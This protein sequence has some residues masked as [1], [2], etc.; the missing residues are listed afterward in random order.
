MLDTIEQQLDL[1]F[2]LV[3]QVAD[4]ILVTDTEGAIHYVNSAFEKSSG[5]TRAEILGKPAN[6]LKSGLHDKAFYTKLWNTITCGQPFA[7]TFINRRK[8]G[9]IFYEQ[10]TIT[11]L[12][13]HS[14]AITHY[15]ATGKDITDA[16]EKEERLHYLS[17][18]DPFTDIPN[19]RWLKQELEHALQAKAAEQDSLAVMVLGL[20]RFKR[21]N[22][23][24][25]RK[26]GDVLMINTVRKLKLALDEQTMLAR[27]GGDVFAFLVHNP[28]SPSA[29]VHTAQALL[30]AIASSE[31]LNDQE[32]AITG[33]IGIS[34]Y[35]DD[36]NSANTLLQNAET[37]MFRAK[38]ELGGN[39]FEFFTP[40]MNSTTL[41]RLSLESALYKALENDEF[42]LHYQP[43][44]DI[45]TGRIIGTE[46][47]LR[48]NN[49]Q[50]G[51][52]GPDEF[53]PILE[54]TGMINR[55]GTWVLHKACEQCAKWH[56]AGYDDLLLSVNISAVQFRHPDLIDTIFSILDDTGL[57]EHHLHLEV[58][59]NTVMQDMDKVVSILN[60]LSSMNVKLSI[61]DFGTGYS[62]LLYLQ[63]FPFDMLKLD[64][65]FV[66][67]IENS[68]SDEAIASAIITLAKTLGLSVVAEGVETRHQLSQLHGL[69]C[70]VMQGYLFSRPLTA[71]DMLLL[72]QSGR[73]L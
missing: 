72:L 2:R 38:Q 52:V 27:M 37:A 29:L 17:H 41:R 7:D 45:A 46:A 53:I 60:T 40:D 73:R 55:V 6:L 36:G 42:S 19:A 33:S 69:G 4:A 57:P 9:S 56:S 50:H 67:N 51:M 28:H 70:D 43:Q 31:H 35:P 62:S 49:P 14:G 54:E 23:L 25:G 71:D 21:I 10:K 1:L 20:D 26:A 15:I 48:W 63:K 24:L 18:H 12:F 47:L 39:C 5:Y 61:D 8:D 66:Q 59:E 65:S 32:I 58:T 34:I 30:S 64:K 68:K 13:N 11:P 16:L 22:E 3:E 44:L